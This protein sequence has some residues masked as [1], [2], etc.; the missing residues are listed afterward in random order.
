MASRAI[1]ITI[2]IR[3]VPLIMK[4]N[5]TEKLIR[6]NFFRSLYDNSTDQFFSHVYLHSFAVR[7]LFQFGSV[8]VSGEETVATSR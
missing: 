3:S 1:Y 4:K 2:W 6:L 7:Q 5:N 8:L